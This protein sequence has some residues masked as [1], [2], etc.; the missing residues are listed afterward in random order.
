MKNA[1]L[2]CYMPNHVNYTTEK[3]EKQLLFN[4]SFRTRKEALCDIPV[5]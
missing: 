5:H 4:P 1:L 2:W 3:G